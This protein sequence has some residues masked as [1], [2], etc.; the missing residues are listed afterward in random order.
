[1][2]KKNKVLVVQQY[3][4][5]DISAVSQLLGDLLTSVSDDDENWDFTVLCGTVAR[6]KI[7]YKRLPDKY[8]SVHIKR[9]H[10]LPFGKKRFLHRVF[11]YSFYYLGVFFYVMFS[12]GYD[13]YI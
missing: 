2:K 13:I 5:P 8:K 12:T 11:E 10:T 1:M 3:F 9:I 4:Y 7:K 6:G